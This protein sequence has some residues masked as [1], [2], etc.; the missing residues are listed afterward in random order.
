MKPA[1]KL[2]EL[3]TKTSPKKCK[4]V[5][6]EAPK[7]ALDRCPMASKDDQDPSSVGWP[8]RCR[9]SACGS[10]RLEDP[11]EHVTMSPSMNALKIHDSIL[12]CVGQT[13]LVRLVNLPKMHGI[14]CQ[15]LAKCEFMNPGGSVKDRIALRMINDAEK[16]GKLVP[17]SGYTIIEPTSGNT[18][19]G[20]A[21]VAA[22]RGYRCIIVMPEKMS[23]EKENVLR[24]LGAEIVRTANVAKFDA[25]G[26]HICK[27]LE[28]LKTIPKSVI[29]NQYR[30]SSNPLCHYDSTAEEILVACQQASQSAGI[31]VA[32][33]DMLVAGTGTGGTLSGLARKFRERVPRCTIVGADPLGSTMAQPERVANGG[34]QK[35]AQVEQMQGAY[36]IEGIGYDFVPTVCDRSLVH[37]WIK[38][39]DGDALRTAR[40]LIRHE[41]LLVGGSSGAAMW[42][43]LEAVRLAGPQLS[44]DPGKRVVVILPDGVRNYMSK[45]VSDSWMRERNFM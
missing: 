17:N 29:L 6:I 14:K 15:I 38:V 34:G 24:C 32:Q 12:D 10:T 3:A 43:A 1:A 45:F 40:Q 13:P 33:V 11:H 23:A 39:A 35:G 25:P 19:I 30:N 20:L 37:Q 2:D 18:G 27:A 21:L 42:A 22:Q 36:E 28:L 31:G 44:Q 26:S 4:K 16:G 8:S 7:E 9:W 5:T 41:S